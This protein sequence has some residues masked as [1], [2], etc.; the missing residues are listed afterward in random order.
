MICKPLF[1][2]SFADVCWGNQDTLITL[3]SDSTDSYILSYYICGRYRIEI[4]YNAY[5]KELFLH[6]MSEKDIAIT[7]K[8]Y[9]DSVKTHKRFVPLFT[10]PMVMLTDSLRRDFELNM[11][12]EE[13][14]RD[15]LNTGNIKVYDFRKKHYLQQVIG[16][17]RT[18][19]ESGYYEYSDSRN[20]NVLLTTTVC[21]PVY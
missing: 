12:V 17:K 10:Q 20:D 15:L 3:H 19:P 5:F 8:R 7:I 6:G 21:E 18:T 1:G 14:V 9:V 13:I 4:G 16:K 2:Q 11:Y